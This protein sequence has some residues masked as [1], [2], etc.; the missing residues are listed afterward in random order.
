MKKLL[1][2][3]SCIS[4]GLLMNGQTPVQ[5]VSPVTHPRVLKEP[6]QLA[7]PNHNTS[8]VAGNHQSA[9]AASRSAKNQL[10]SL[11]DLANGAKLNEQR[12]GS[13]G[14]L[15]TVSEAGCNQLSVDAASSAVVFIH[16][17]D[18][19]EFPTT[20]LAQ[21]GYDISKDGGLNWEPNLGPI[22]VDAQIDNNNVNGR[23][24]Q[25]VLYN[26]S[27]ASTYDSTF[28]VYSGTW[29]DD[30]SSCQESSSH[31]AGQMR[32]TAQMDSDASTY[33]VS[34]DT[35]NHTLDYIAT[36]FCT[37]APG[38]FWN[39]NEANSGNLASSVD[40][41]GLI[42]EKGVWNA[43]TRRVVWV[44]NLIPQQFD[45]VAGTGNIASIA[46]SFDIAF[47]PTGQYGWIA[48]L[49]DVSSNPTDSVYSP[50]FW[51]S[52]DSGATWQGPMQLSLDS[53][54][55][56][57]AR[58]NHNPFPDY[59][60]NT[61]TGVPTTSFEGKLVV[62][63]LGNPHFFTTVGNGGGYAITEGAGYM[64][65]DI[66]Y[67]ANR[68]SCDS[69]WNGW[70][71]TLVDSVY[72]LSGTYT[73]DGEI[74]YNRPL[75]STSAD[76]KKIFFYWLD[77]DT[78]I[79]SGLDTNEYPNLFTRAFDLVANSATASVNLTQNDSLFGGSTALYPSGGL[80]PP[81]ANFPVVAVHALQQD[82]SFNVGVVL[83]QIDY[84]TGGGVIGSYANPAAFWYI[85]NIT[86][87]PSDYISPHASVQIAGLD[88]EVVLL[89][90]DYNETGATI[91]YG[92]TS[93][94]QT[95]ALTL[96]IDSSNFNIAATGTYVIYY[97][98]ENGAGA[99]LAAASRIV[100]VVAPPIANFGYSEPGQG[101]VAF[102]DSSL[103]QPTFWMWNFGDGSTDSVSYTENPTHHYLHDGT[104]NVCLYDTN[105]YGNSTKCRNIS[106]ITGI[107]DIGLSQ[108]ISV[109]PNP[110]TG[111]VFITVDASIT[112]DYT[113]TVYDMLGNAVM[114]PAAH[115][116]GTSN[117]QIDLSLLANGTYMIKVQT[118]TQMAVKRLDLIRK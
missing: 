64:G 52:I 41:Y 10:K 97:Y 79:T 19:Y 45:S 96:V 87:A 113:V 38:V 90:H 105:A 36:G 117:T 77:T 91:I 83:T 114:A 28:L 72:T 27:G 25:G 65:Y 2:L 14:N 66:N 107:N 104:Y 82:Q 112:S 60:Q 39:I 35:V 37:G 6:K 98:A 29:H 9:P 42:V 115:K 111:L 48:C 63:Y 75:A 31:W 68:A 17:Q 92:D 54:P 81:G 94:F 16:R 51:H 69:N 93:C 23:Y 13:A 20:N 62:D 21:Y 44:D 89:G 78:G 33:N 57:V 30:C 84:E 102:T 100:E 108:H 67:N 58:L 12:I 32:G 34:I 18:N 116:A 95:G 56:V 59:I 40:V 101:Y 3:V 50:I 53:L 70:A 4:A 110:S 5:M 61:T 74:E 43:A 106:V 55:G 80:Y 46:T 109:F 8:A 86:Y 118:G 24:P 85:D 22:T 1:L 49:G 7:Q 73:T 76:G 11:A 71:A 103:N 15:L 47:D 26:P 99:I 88:T